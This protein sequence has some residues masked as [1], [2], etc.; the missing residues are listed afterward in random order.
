MHDAVCRP[1][2]TKLTHQAIQAKSERNLSGVWDH[3]AMLKLTRG[4]EPKNDVAM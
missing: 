3:D 2:D 1:K 4:V